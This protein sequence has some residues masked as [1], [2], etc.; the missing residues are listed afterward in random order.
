MHR[1]RLTLVDQRTSAASPMSSSRLP[2][3]PAWPYSGLYSKEPPTSSF[4]QPGLDEGLRQ[5]VFQSFSKALNRQRNARP[6]GVYPRRFR[7]KPYIRVYIRVL[8][9]A[10]QMRVS[11]MYPRDLDASHLGSSTSQTVGWASEWRTG[12]PC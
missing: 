1:S 10:L 9:I 6:S 11:T 7:S 4:R 5:R 12:S 2:S 3:R 8:F